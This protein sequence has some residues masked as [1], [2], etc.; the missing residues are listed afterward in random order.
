M[1]LSSNEDP[2]YRFMKCSKTQQDLFDEYGDIRHQTLKPP[3]A[4]SVCNK[5]KIYNRYTDVLCLDKT[6]VKLGFPNDEAKKQT[7]KFTMMGLWSDSQTDLDY[8]HANYVSGFNSEGAFTDKTFIAAQGPTDETTSHFWE[9]IIQQN[10]TSVVCLTNMVERNKLKCEQYF[11]TN[12][13]ETIEFADYFADKTTKSIEVL[14]EE[15]L[16]TDRNFKICKL[17][18][19]FNRDS[20]ILTRRINH[21]FY[22][23]WPDHGIPDG[24][25]QVMISF[26]EKVKEFDLKLK[27]SEERKSELSNADFTYLKRNQTPLIVHCSAGIGRTGTYILIDQAIHNYHKVKNN[28]ESEHLIKFDENFI[29]KLAI[30]IREQRSMAIQTPDQYRYCYQAVRKYIADRKEEEMQPTADKKVKL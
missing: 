6:R 25:E 10:V 17:K 29:R 19:K 16:H 8:I 2:F 27:N 30:S 12:K 20:K 5:H 21:C 18:I 1:T 24:D 14:N 11:P 22:Q 7:K 15:T 13:N 26:I 9:M 4:Y 28:D 23:T 3:D